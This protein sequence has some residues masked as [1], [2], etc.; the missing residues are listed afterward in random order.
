M[1]G[2]RM[3][4]KLLVS[5]IYLFIYYYLYIIYRIYSIIAWEYYYT[6]ILSLLFTCGGYQKYH[7]YSDSKNILNTG[8]NI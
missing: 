2:H 8:V 7:S 1:S 3:I 4:I 6:M 5:R